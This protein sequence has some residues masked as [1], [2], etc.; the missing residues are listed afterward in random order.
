MLIRKIRPSDNPFIEQI[1]K[2]S[3]VEFGLPMTGTAYEDK[4]TQYMYEAYQGNRAIYF[5]LEDKG[6]VVGGGG[7]KALQGNTDNICELQKMYFAPEARGKG[8]GKVMFDKC[9]GA[10]KKFD[11]TQCYLE[12]AGSL[13][14]A[15]HI[16]EKNGFKHLKGSLGGTGHY[17]CG[18]WMLK[19]LDTNFTNLH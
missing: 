16:Y 1:I 4:D 3:L 14:A 19:D 9:I 13:K 10:A 6:T 2:S 5:V 7:I 12:S 11:Y 17:S 8:Y 15:I 18:V